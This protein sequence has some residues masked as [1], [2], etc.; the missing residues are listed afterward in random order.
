LTPSVESPH[1]EEVDRDGP[2]DF[3]RKEEVEPT[4]PNLM[5]P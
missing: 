3:E 2:T 1:G 4:L 5:K